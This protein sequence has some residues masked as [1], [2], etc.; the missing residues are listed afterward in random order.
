[1]ARRLR[2]CLLACA[3]LLAVQAVAPAG[4]L[5]DYPAVTPGY[6]LRFPQDHGAHPAFRTEWWYITGWLR[7]QGEAPIGFQLTF[8]RSR[9]PLDPRNPSRFAPA[10]LLFA[11]AALADPAIGRLRHDQRAARAGFGLAEAAVG[12]TRVHIGDW[13]LARD[14]QGRY[15]S[16]IQAQTFTLD[17]AFAP[18]GPIL[19]EGDAGYSRKGPLP[20]QASYY[21]SQPQLAVGGHVERDG[22]RT[23]VTGTAWLDHEWSSEILAADGVG[24]DWT[25]INLDD[26]GAVMAF[27][28]RDRAGTPLWAGGT[29]RRA[30][31]GATALAPDAIEFSPRRHWRSPRTEANYPVALRLRA[32][33]LVLDLD[34]LMDDQELDSRA[35]TGGVY[36]EGAVSASRGGQRVGRGYLELTGYFQPL[37][38]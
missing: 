28:I 4:G 27:R 12:D 20:A 6:V 14:A 29:V 18:T 31:G 15:R 13:S 23:E 30:D 19:L 32:G 11:H 1:M 8:F 7:T 33:D 37:D 38:F 2:G 34:P 17:L 21:Y 9:P 10:E 25:G 16:L 35:S 3:L 26:G 22:R 36:W 24:W 5:P